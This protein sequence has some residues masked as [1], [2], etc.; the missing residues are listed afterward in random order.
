MFAAAAQVPRLICISLSKGLYA[1]TPCRIKSTEQQA[2]ALAIVHAEFILIHPFREGN[3][4]CARLLAVLMGL[5]AGLPALDFGLPQQT[6]Y[7]RIRR[8][9][10]RYRH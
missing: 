7:L 2:A 3:G 9:R 5:Q 4:R 10:R 1:C 8:R 6:Q